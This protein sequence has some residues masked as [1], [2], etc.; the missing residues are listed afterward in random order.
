MNAHDL[1]RRLSRPLA[2]IALAHLRWGAPTIQTRD[3]CSETMREPWPGHDTAP[4]TGAQCMARP[5][6]AAI[7]V[8]A[9]RVGWPTGYRRDLYVHD[10]NACARLPADVPFVFVLR[11]NGTHLFPV[12]YRD[13]AG[14]GAPH[15][16]VP[17]PAIFRYE[18]SRV[19]TWDGSRLTAHR[20]PE[21]AAE[22][23]RELESAYLG[24]DGAQ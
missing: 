20:T 5:H 11:E 14:H 9:E 16:A 6:Y 3:Y 19:Y 1:P 10:R 22:R 15:F 18:R 23:A 4:N 24:R 21:A 12:T 8:E 17:C 13:G 2:S 7:V